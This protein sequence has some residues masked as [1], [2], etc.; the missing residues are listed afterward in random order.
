MK[1]I[2]LFQP[3]PLHKA[4][5]K[6]APEFDMVI[7]LAAEKSAAALG[8]RAAELYSLKDKAQVEKIAA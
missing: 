4:Y 3:S 1:I 6:I 5:S 2:E 7:S 8:E